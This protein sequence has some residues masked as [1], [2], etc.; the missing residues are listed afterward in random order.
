MRDPGRTAAV[1][2]DFLIQDSFISGFIFGCSVA[3][4]IPANV[5]YRHILPDALIQSDLQLVHS[6]QDS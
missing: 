5:Q 2:L 1:V 3:V 6:S 4:G